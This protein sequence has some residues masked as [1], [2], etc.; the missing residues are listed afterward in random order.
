MR[1]L[2]LLIVIVVAAALGGR[3]LL[4][5]PG[6]VL[7]IRDNL[8]LE[9]TLGFALLALLC[10]AV[11]LAVLTLLL[12]ALWD[13]SGLGRNSRW[14][15]WLARRR[16]KSALL[17][18]IDGDWPRAARLFH[19][20]AD[21]EW[22]VAAGIG[23]A[24]AARAAGDDEQA[25]A[26]LEQLA[27]QRHGQLAADLMMAR[28]L[29]DEGA[30]RQARARL[31]GLSGKSVKGN[32]HRVRLLAEALERERDWPTLVTLLPALKPVMRDHKA[33]A[34]RELNAWSGLLEAVA[35]APG[36]PAARLNE[37]RRSWK[38]MPGP[39]QR[40]SVLRAAYA[41]YLTALGEGAAA[42]SLV[43]KEIEHH[44]DDRLIAVLEQIE[45]VAPEKLLQQLELWLETRPASPALLICAGR[46]ALRAK[47]WGKARSFFETAARSGNVHAL[48]ELARLYSSL[49]DGDRALS[50]LERRIA[51]LNESLPPLPQPSPRRDTEL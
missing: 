2:L 19:S 34:A 7:V 39:L 37:L 41:R 29:L 16:L 25:R 5:D 12:A 18:M 26:A 50:A 4:A 48:A 23:E 31:E 36:E 3:W 38:S 11:L 27:G 49:G 15:G 9:S 13:I 8:R 42:F 40:Q 14:H 10:A 43:R 32:P 21:S 30:V 46:V 17:A 45:D 47:L 6:Y 33:F 22:S 51:L 28:M 35:T 24:L 44:W 1:M 20:T